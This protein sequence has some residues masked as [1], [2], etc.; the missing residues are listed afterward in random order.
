[1][2]TLC[3]I[4]IKRLSSSSTASSVDLHNSTNS[5]SH[6]VLI[7]LISLQIWQLTIQNC[8]KEVAVRADGSSAPCT[9]TKLAQAEVCEGLKSC[10]V[11]HS[12]QEH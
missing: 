2:H 10:L 12:Q 7:T 5:L 4:G 1:M 3:R 9:V 8:G 11:S 6:L